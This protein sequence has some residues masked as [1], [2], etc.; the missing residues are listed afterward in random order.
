MHLL[1]QLNPAISKDHQ[2]GTYYMDHS[3][4]RGGYTHLHCVIGSNPTWHIKVQPIT[5][6]DQVNMHAYSLQQI[7]KMHGISARKFKAMI[8]GTD[9]DQKALAY[10]MWYTACLPNLFSATDLRIDHSHHMQALYGDQVDPH[11]RFAVYNAIVQIN[12]LNDQ[13]YNYTLLADQ[14]GIN[15]DQYKAMLFACMRQQ[16]T[17]LNHINVMLDP[18]TDLST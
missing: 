7:T 10:S 17:L 12:L 8:N 4:D 18:T 6:H 13:R 14:G 9:H 11:V 5:T 15:Q 2:W 1:A 3:L 16:T